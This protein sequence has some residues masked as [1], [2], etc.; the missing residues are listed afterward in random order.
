MGSS[1]YRSTPGEKRRKE[2]LSVTTSQSGTGMINTA[3][4][5]TRRKISS[6][7]MLASTC[8]AFLPPELNLDLCTYQFRGGAGGGRQESRLHAT[9]G[10]SQ[11]GSGSKKLHITNNPDL[12]YERILS[13]KKISK[14]RGSLQIK[15]ELW[16]IAMYRLN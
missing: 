2:T 7:C 12:F 9:A 1:H 4:D 8:E 10:C 3:A 14:W 11:S 5:I 16:Q 6:V 15:N 13:R